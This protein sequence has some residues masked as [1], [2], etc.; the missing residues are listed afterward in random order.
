MTRAIKLGIL[1]SHPIQYFVPVYRELVKHEEIELSVIYRT[2]AGIDHYDDE[3][4]GQE[5]KWDIPLLNGYNHCFLSDKKDLNKV[6]PNIIKYLLQKK[7]DVLLIHGYNSLTNILAILAAKLTGTRIILRGDSRLSSSHLR[8]PTKKLL[9]RFLFGLFDGFA[10]IGSPNKDY[11]LA[12]GV[13]EEKFFFAPFSVENR[14]FQMNEHEHMQ[15]R[16]NLRAQLQIDNGAICFLSASKLISRKRIDDLIAAFSKIQTSHPEAFLLIAGSGKEANFL[17]DQATQAGIQNIRFLGF[18]NQ[19]ELPALYAASDIFVLPSSDEP[20]GLAVNEAMAAGLPVIVSDE[21]GAASDLVDGKGTG[22][23][24]PCGDVIGLA[25]AMVTLLN[26][27]ER[28]KTMAV[29]AVNLIAKWSTPEC[30]HKLAEMTR[31][32]ATSSSSL[33]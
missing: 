25:D 27:P 8:S 20:W 33:R 12:H 10:C 11:Y 9:K 32:V 16:E 15:V 1:V 26:E 23:V 24:Y 3:D 4:F 13:P 30:A 28:R 5:I 31:L 19:S 14:T 2:R 29:A 7:F 17:Q 6:E 22:A 18:Q 21:V